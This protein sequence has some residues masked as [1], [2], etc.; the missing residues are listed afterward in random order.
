VKL[1]FYV[2]VCVSSFAVADILLFPAAEQFNIPIIQC[3]LKVLKMTV[4]VDIFRSF[5]GVDSI[6]FFPVFC[7]CECVCVCVCVW[8]CV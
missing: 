6:A 1:F 4:L 3:H 8:V 2:C 5:L 7:V